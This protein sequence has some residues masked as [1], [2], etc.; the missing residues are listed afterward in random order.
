ML[1]FAYGMLLPTE[2]DVK[3]L[4]LQDVK[5]YYS[6]NFGAQRSHLYVAGKFDK[7]AVKKAI[8]DSFEDV[9]HLP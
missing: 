6:S 4:T 9:E 3:R 8:A 2:D 5:D 1:L 7:S